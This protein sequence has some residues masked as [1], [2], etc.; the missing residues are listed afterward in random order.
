MRD[1]ILGKSLES[2]VTELRRDFHR[3]PEL[4][5]EEKRTAA[6]IADCL[7]QL[8]IAAETFGTHH[9]VGGVITGG[10][11]GPT[12]ALRADMDALPIQEEPDAPYRSLTPGVMHACGHDAHM[13]MLLGA[14]ALL[15]RNRE[16]LAGT[17]KLVFQP[18]EE[19]NPVGGAQL[20]LREGFL[21]DAAAI[22]GL[23]V[24]PD[25]PTGHVGVKPG[26]LM[27]ASDRFTVRIM[28]KG[29]HAGQPHQ[30]VDAI[31]V[32]AAVINSFSHLISRQTN[33]VDTATLSIG[34]IH[35]GERYNVI[36]REVVMEGTIRT[37]DEATRRE[38]PAQMKK[39]LAGIAQAYGATFALDHQ[40][41]YPVLNNW[42]GPTRTVI[43]A[44]CRVAGKEQVHTDV[45]PELGAEDFANYLTRIPGAFFWL[46]CSAAG[47]KAAALHNSGFCLDEAALPV[48]A[49]LLY[50]IAVDALAGCRGAGGDGSAA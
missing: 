24:W 1:N 8:G 35:G 12:V 16:S 18:A 20:I 44:A 42:S 23:H 43:D 31:T 30:G 32:G 7:R 26:A 39:L 28:G 17:V 50:Q 36:A 3:H 10:K 9:G 22:F 34:S 6:V 2:L 46:G 15:V 33:P 47:E 27:A 48:G 40:P 11:P 19:A 37:L 45:K 21:D 25:L 13:A 4:S 14:A 49:K 38:I 29:A 5:G 41:G